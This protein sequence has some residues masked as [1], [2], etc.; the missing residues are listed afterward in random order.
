MRGSGL[1][2]GPESMAQS[3]ATIR[4]TSHQARRATAHPARTEPLHACTFINREHLSV[5]RSEQTWAWVACTLP[6]A[7][8]VTAV[9]LLA[10]STSPRPD[11]A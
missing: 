8:Q 10:P 1:P 6:I 3:K 11:R 7:L 4:I 5:T 2:L 9:E